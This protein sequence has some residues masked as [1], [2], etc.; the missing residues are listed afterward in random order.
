MFQLKAVFVPFALLMV[1]YRLVHIR[2]AK[3]L[4]IVLFNTSMVYSILLFTEYAYHL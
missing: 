1:I 3:L 4:F 2:F